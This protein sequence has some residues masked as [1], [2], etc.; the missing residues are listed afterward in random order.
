MKGAKDQGMT[1][2]EV[3]IAISVFMIAIGFILKGNAVAH[4]YYDQAQLRQQMLFFASGMVDAQLE[5]I[6]PPV[7]IK[8]FSDF[9]TKIT[10]TPVT[11]HLERI[12]VEISIKDYSNAPDP[13]S[14]YTYR[15]KE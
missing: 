1:V 13:V 5:G 4:R 3:V 7:D 15:V 10:V 9:E 12:Q 8:P 6:T 11:E 14:L 2:L